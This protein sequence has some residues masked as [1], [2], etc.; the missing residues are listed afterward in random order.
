MNSEKMVDIA[1]KDHIHRRVATVCFKT[2][3][4]PDFP[5]LLVEGP[6]PGLFRSGIDHEDMH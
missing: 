3:G 5:K 1:Q 4:S 6:L 2:D